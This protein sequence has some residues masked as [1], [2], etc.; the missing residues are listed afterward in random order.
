MKQ[1]EKTSNSLFYFSTLTSLYQSVSDSSPNFSSCFYENHPLQ[2]STEGFKSSDLDWNQHINVLFVDEI[3]LRTV[4]TNQDVLGSIKQ[5]WPLCS[6][7]GNNRTIWALCSLSCRLFKALLLLLAICLSV[8]L[9]VTS[10][11]QRP[12]ST[13]VLHHN[14]RVRMFRHWWVCGRVAAVQITLK[15]PQRGNELQS[16]DTASLFPRGSGAVLQRWAQRPRCGPTERTTASP[17]P[18][19]GAGAGTGP[20]QGENQQRHV[21]QQT[22]CYSQSDKTQRDDRSV[23]ATQVTPTRWLSISPLVRRWLT[24]GMC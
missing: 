21:W 3:H 4:K 14:K 13:E 9:S 5:C 23:N 20:G 17:A 18:E 16:C 10:S 19:G 12:D 1:P 8:C 24:H 2:S 6:I 22:H 7:N 11:A 15:S